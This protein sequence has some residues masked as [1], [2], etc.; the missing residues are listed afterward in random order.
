MLAHMK[1]GSLSWWIW[2]ILAGLMLWGLT[3]QMLAR[4]AALALAVLQ[5]IGY[6]LVHRSLNH[7]PTQ[8]RSAYFL[9]MAVSLVPSLA[10]MYWILAAGTTA[11][12]LTGYCAMA[13]LLLLL[14]WNRSVPLTWSRIKTIA[15][16]PPIQG[17]VI[18]GLPL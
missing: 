1:I 13:R 3:G 7:F 10:I 11:R 12:V 16:H 2:A 5:A 18:N 6:L 9:W 17:S 14:P 15:F 4:E 8:L